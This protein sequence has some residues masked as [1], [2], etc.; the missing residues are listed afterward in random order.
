MNKNNPNG[1]NIHSARPLKPPFW[2]LPIGSAL[3][4]SG[5]TG[6]SSAIPGAGPT[7]ELVGT[8]CSESVGT[9]CSELACTACLELVCTACPELVCTAC[10]EL[11]C[12]T[13]PEL[14]CSSCS[15]LFCSSCG[16]STWFAKRGR[17]GVG[18]KSI[19]P[20]PGKYAAGQECASRSLT[21]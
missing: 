12:T 17:L 18:S 1:S 6:S 8:A 4:A 9:S 5:G 10:P 19:H 15:G 7:S 16:D 13:C 2:P 20:Y 14:V 21:T 3:E 11:V